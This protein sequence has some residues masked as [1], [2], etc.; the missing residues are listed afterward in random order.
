MKFPAIQISLKHNL[1]IARFKEFRYRTRWHQI[2]LYAHLKFEPKLTNIRLD[3]I[4]AEFP[5]LR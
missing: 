1:F 4:E 5:I 2:S 3:E